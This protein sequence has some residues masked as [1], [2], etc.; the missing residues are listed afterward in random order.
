MIAGTHSG[1]GKTTVTC[2][3]IQSLVNRGLPVTAYKCGP[4][5]IDPLFHKKVIGAESYNLDSFFCDK[6]TI[7]YLLNRESESIAV[8]EGVMGCYD[9]VHGDYSSIKTAVDTASPVVLVIDCKGMSTS[10]AAVMK[11]YLTYHQPNNIIGFIFNRLPDSLVST[12]QEFCDEMNAVY[13]GRLPYCKENVIPNRH[14]GLNF[15]IHNAELKQKMNTLSQLA[16]K[17][18]LIDKLIEY[19]LS[20]VESFISPSFKP[21][22]RKPLRIAVT[23]D[24]SFCFSY[25]DNVN[26]L[27]SL[28]CEIA[29][30]SPLHDKRLPDNIYGLILNGGYPELYAKALSENTEMLAQLKSIIRSGIPTIAECGGFMYLHEFIESDDGKD[31][32]MVGALKGKCFKTD[33]LQRFGY[34][35]LTAKQDNMLCKKGE[36]IKA[37]EFHYWKSTNPG[38]G[39]ISTKINGSSSCECVH[40]SPCLYAGFPHLYFYSNPEYA[41][42]FVRR[43][44]EFK[45][46]GKIKENNTR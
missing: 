11:G 13:F 10:I 17:N 24:E 4:D 34:V 8:I 3:I 25:R 42:N 27:E 14:L 37:H 44:K 18:I 32:S 35:M 29:E 5:Y 16:E 6:D 46:N 20:D 31:Y 15:D 26:M 40:S 30:F 23:S 43:V 12:A 45:E 1:C 9:G 21:V 2:A 7:N 33:K 22:D 38:N 39:F 41:E 28:G 19:S 36:A